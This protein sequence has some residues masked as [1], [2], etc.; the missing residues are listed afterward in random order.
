MKVMVEKTN[1]ANHSDDKL[2]ADNMS[3]EK[4]LSIPYSEPDTCFGSEDVDEEKCLA[5]TELDDYYNML[6][7]VCP[8][9]LINFYNNF[10]IHKCLRII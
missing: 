9:I 1:L 7:K 4:I 5:V 10:R 8:K 6:L 2:A 3:D